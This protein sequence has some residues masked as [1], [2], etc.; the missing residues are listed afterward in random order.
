M[1][2]EDEKG[3]YFF[4]TCAHV[5]GENQYAYSNV[6][7]ATI[8]RNVI[9]RYPDSRTPRSSE[10][11]SLDFSLVEVSPDKTLSCTFGLKT[12]KGNFINMQ[13][14]RG[15]PLEV[16]YRTIYKWGA[17][18][19]NRQVGRCTGCEYDGPFLYLQVDTKEFA[20]PGDSGAIICVGDNPDQ[21][22]AAFV[23][24]SI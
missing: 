20:K 2:L 13:I 24:F 21:S 22:L 11:P 23:L 17:S 10:E 4:T 6:N 16:R 14:F 8:G 19:P 3:T 12:Q 18:E 1:F 9:I 15:D 5:I 7:N